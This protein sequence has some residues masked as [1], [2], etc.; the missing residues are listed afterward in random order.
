MLPHNKSASQPSS[1]ALSTRDLIQRAEGYRGNYLLLPGQRCTPSELLRLAGLPPLTGPLAQLIDAGDSIAHQPI[2]CPPDRP[3]LRQWNPYSGTWP[4]HLEY[5]LEALIAED[6]H[7]WL[8]KIHEAG[9]RCLFDT[10]HELAHGQITLIGM[11]GLI[12]S[13][14]LEELSRFHLLGEA[15]AVLIGD[16]EGPELLEELCYFESF[17][18]P[19]RQRSHAVA[20]NPSQ[21]LRA[22]GLTNSEQRAQWLFELY[23]GGEASVP[24][25][26][27]ESGLGRQA[28]AFLCEEGAY[29]EKARTLVNPAWESGYWSRPMI[30]RWR[31][32]FVPA[33]AV[34]LP[35]LKEPLQSIEDCRHAWRE[36]TLDW[37]GLPPALERGLQRRLAIQRW[38]LKVAELRGALEHP[39][40]RIPDAV[41]AEAC[42]GLDQDWARLITFFKPLEEPLVGTYE[43][44]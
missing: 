25:S 5:S 19:S 3:L 33:R 15:L 27:P 43:C 28:L 22:I 37:R 31:Q 1:S 7:R 44:R 4:L 16:L 9:T 12:G 21:A 17:W 18:P 11:L 20:F 40:A 13:M 32:D 6:D 42:A 10:I 14:H 8:I 39:R 24:I 2:I 41:R 30:Q 35:W 38:A 23:L 29:A 26:P 36:I 34:K